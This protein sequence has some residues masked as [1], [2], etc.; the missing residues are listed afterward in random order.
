MRQTAYL[1]HPSCLLH[2]MG[3]GHPESPARLQAIDD[4]LIAQRVADFLYKVDAPKAL[5]SQLERVHDAD[6]VAGI[7][8]RAPKTGVLEIDPDTLMTPHTLEAALHA[9]GA[10][11]AAVD[12]VLSGKALNAFCSVRPP[13]HH[14]EHDRAMG[15]CFF[16]NVAVAAAHALT[17]GGL[18]RVAILDFDVHHGNGTE[19][20]FQGN[21]RVLYCSIF[22]YPFYPHVAPGSPAPNIVRC[23]LPAGSDGEAYRQA[24]ETVWLPYMRRFEPQML[25]I[26]A[27]FDA[28]HMDPLADMRLTEADFQWMTQTLVDYARAHCH[29][30]IVSTLEGG[31]DLEALAR[32]TCVHIKTLMGM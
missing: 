7:I 22:Q 16:N 9:A 4:Q 21:D 14:A 1:T 19:H 27:G 3:R 11:I 10:S 20:I 26:S 23:P 32:S 6:Y 17:D 25:L 15:F 30:R 29:D 12:L 31:Y 8:A 28:H 18:D 2:D 24:V 13:G 5:V